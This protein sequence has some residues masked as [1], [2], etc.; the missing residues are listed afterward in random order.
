MYTQALTTMES[1]H[2]NLITSWNYL[3]ISTFGK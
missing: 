3:L 2:R 1:Y